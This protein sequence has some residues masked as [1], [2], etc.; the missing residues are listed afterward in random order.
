M[1]LPA[2]RIHH[3]RWSYGRII[4]PPAFGLGLGW[5]DSYGL[6]RLDAEFHNCR[7]TGIY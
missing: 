3:I 4:V 5:F 6:R 2:D 7:E 1:N